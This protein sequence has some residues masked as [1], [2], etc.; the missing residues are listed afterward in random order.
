[1]ALI[2]EFNTRIPLQ[3]RVELSNA[4]DDEDATT[5][6]TVKIAA[7]IDDVTGDFVTYAGVALDDT[8]KEH[9]AHAIL[10][11]VLYLEAYK[12]DSQKA[13]EK[14]REWQTHVDRHLRRTQGNNR[15][16]P[17]SSSK[18]TPADENPSGMPLEPDF[19]PNS[20]FDPYIPTRRPNRGVR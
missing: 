13:W 5:P 6:D 8:N 12:G 16:R 19:D 2:D 7:A 17:K 18:L 20:E 3:R 4:T 14:V 1:M 9:V 10:G 11:I 15:I